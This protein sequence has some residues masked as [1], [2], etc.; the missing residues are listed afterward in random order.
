M[1]RCLASSLALMLA[2]G[3]CAGGI[4][5]RPAFAHGAARLTAATYHGKTI[6]F[7]YPGAWKVIPTKEAMSLGGSFLSAAAG[8]SLRDVAGVQITGAHRG[9]VAVVLHANFGKKVAGEIH[10]QH[11]A[12]MVGFLKGVQGSKGLRTLSSR[13][14][15]LSGQPAQTV[16]V[17]VTNTKPQSRQQYTV[18]ISGD[19]KSIYLTLY[20][21][22]PASLWSSYS[23]AFAGIERSVHIR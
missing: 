12:F 16:D 22:A 2:A 9:A 3:L 17:L 19:E 1:R 6:T 10:G 14:G 8:F 23:A 5:A 15:T 4:S 11:K 21:T 7:S 20:L 18:A 13:T